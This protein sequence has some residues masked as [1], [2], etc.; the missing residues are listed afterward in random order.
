MI[1]SLSHAACFANPAPSRPALSA[2]GNKSVA[3][4]LPDRCTGLLL[5]FSLLFWSLMGRL[6][7]EDIAWLEDSVISQAREAVVIINPR[8]GV[9]STGFFVSSD[10]WVLTSAASLEG[11]REVV[12]ITAEQKTLTGTKLV[13]IDPL[14]DLAIVATGTRVRHFLE[15]RDLPAVAG[16]ACAVVLQNGKGSLRSTDGILLAQR[17]ILDWT[18]QRLLRVWSVALRPDAN[19]IT[20]APVITREGKVAAMCDIV[21]GQP[22]QKFVFAIPDTAIAALLKR[23]RLDKSPVSFPKAGEISGFG[24]PSGSE[25]VGAMKLLSAGNTEGALQGFLAALKL[26]P[27]NPIVLRQAALCYANTGRPADASAMVDQALRIAPGRMDLRDLHG[28]FLSAQGDH[29]KTVAYFQELTASMPA[30]GTGWGRLSESLLKADRAQEALQ[31][32]QKWTQLEPDSIFAWNVHA[33]ALAATGAF[34]AAAE[35][36][37]RAEKLEKIFYTLRFSAPQRD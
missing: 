12:I 37:T 7:A 9:A 27:D 32:S 17:D 29:R 6:P 18:E 24:V 13:A 34:D 14:S 3:V 11:L 20:G 2:T 16:D 23:A 5:L 26:H 36:N 4:F 35:A 1:P 33:A 8:Q 31:T 21:S 30:Y 19:G 22:P 15:V 10:G 25:Y 28:Q